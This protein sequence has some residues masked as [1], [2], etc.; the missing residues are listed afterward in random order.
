MCI[1]DRRQAID[2]IMSG[3]VSDAV[4]SSFLTALAMKG[5]TEEETRIIN[6]NEK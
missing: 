6:K 1:R 5:E 3:E 4:I 2:E